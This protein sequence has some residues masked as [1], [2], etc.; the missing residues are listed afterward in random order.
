M[1]FKEIFNFKDIDV[2]NKGIY[3]LI[4]KGEIMNNL[5]LIVVFGV[6]F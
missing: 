3:Y 6:G 1:I 4:L 2:D 5:D